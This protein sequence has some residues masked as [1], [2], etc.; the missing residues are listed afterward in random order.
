MEA[1]MM[2][3]RLRK[4]SLAILIAILVPRIATAI[5]YYNITTFGAQNFLPTA[6]INDAGVIAG[7]TYSNVYQSSTAALWD[8]MLHD[9]GAFDGFHSSTASAIN[10]SNVVVGWSL[11]N[12]PPY[13]EG[14]PFHAFSYDGTLHDLG[15]L[16]GAIST[17]FAVN[18]SGKVVGAA[19]T[20]AGFSHA[21]LYDDTMHDLGT[22]GGNRS[23]AYGINN[24][25]LVVGAADI[26]GNQRQHAFFY[27]GTMHDLATLLNI[28]GDSKAV[29]VNSAG[30]VVGTG[31]QS[32]FVYD[33]T[34]H[35]LGTF[36]GTNSEA[37]AINDSGQ[38]VGDADTPF[39][40][41]HAF[42]Y[43]AVHGMVDLNSLLKPGEDWV[44]SRAVAI[45][46]LGQ[47]LAFGS[48]G[49]CLLTPALPG[50]V[51]SDNIVNGQDIA[52]V[53]SNWLETPNMHHDPLAGDANF[54]DIVNGQDIALIASN[55][56][57]AFPNQG[58]SQAVPE[59]AGI[60]L[61]AAGLVLAS[62]RWR[63]RS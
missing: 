32:A 26:A 19:N 45:N 52:L 29:A 40:G 48:H 34:L 33:S 17:A 41:S 37:L 13:G 2:R 25:G 35:T 5:D 30:T 47:I 21:F 14:S 58:P 20:S 36:G 43:D 44:L 62:I 39:S 60:V 63:R 27:D 54:D 61:A 51:N 11:V 50:D 23:F 15:T 46:N 9:L 4:V 8:G 6:D 56:L 49:Y 57:L 28:S 16:G 10:S 42:L 1:M 38:V 12:G 18:D 24:N 7:S 22:L 31:G 3:P 59:P 55:W 53:A